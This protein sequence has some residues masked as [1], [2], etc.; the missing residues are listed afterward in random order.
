MTTTIKE[1]REELERMSN[2]TSIEADCLLMIIGETKTY[3][4]KDLQAYQRLRVRFT[5]LKD[6][7]GRRYITKMCGN[8]VQV[9]RIENEVKK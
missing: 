8:K 4:I 7:T 2:V 3:R 1:R 5:R 6:S 9:S